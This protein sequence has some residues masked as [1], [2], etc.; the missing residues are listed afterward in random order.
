MT[1]TEYDLD[2]ARE[3]ELFLRRHADGMLAPDR[4]DHEDD[5]PLASALIPALGVE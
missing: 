5:G 2:T 3:V 1:T 4:R